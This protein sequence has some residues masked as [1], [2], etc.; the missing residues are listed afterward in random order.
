MNKQRHHPPRWANRLLQWY[1]ASHLLEEIEG[2][3][4]EEFDY[5]IAKSGLF[6][7]KIDYIRNV[8]GFLKP[9]AMRRKK[10]YT[11][12][13]SSM[14]MI[15]HYLLMAFRNLVR[16]KAFGAIN[17][18][19]LAL[20]MTCCIFIYLWIE[21]E[22]SMDNFHVNG[23]HLF[24]VYQT[25][26]AEGRVEGSYNTPIQYDS[27]GRIIPI[28]DIGQVAPEVKSISFFATGYEL[29]W[30]HPETL[31]VGDRIHKWNGARANE[32]FL[33]MFS[34]PVIAGDAATALRGLNSMAISKKLAAVYFGSPENAIGKSIRYENSADFV[35]NAVFENLPNQS[36]QQFE[37]LLN[38]ES[39]MTRLP[40]ASPVALTTLQ[41]VDGADVRNVE[42]KL[43]RLM[44][45]RMDPQA[46]F[47]IQLGLQPFRDQYLI[48][49]FVNGKPAGGR[50]QYVNIFTAV[51]LFIL[52]IACINFM[53]LATARSIRRAKEVGV[54]KAVGSS[55]VGLIGQFFGE[56]MVFSFIALLLSIVL[57]YCLLPAFNLF[58]GKSIA[59]PFHSVRTVLGLLSL[60]V[61]TGF[62]S[63]SYPALFLSSLKPAGI[64]KGAL[65]F[66]KT[67]IFFRK[68]LASFQFA[69]SI[70]LLI[71]TIVMTRQTQFISNANIG[72]DRENLIYISI[73]GVLSGQQGYERFKHELTKIPGVLMVDRATET[74]HAMTF[75]V[76]LA[77]DGKTETA[78][79]SDAIN[80]EGKVNGSHAGFKPMS[81]GFDFIPTLNLKVAEGRGF[82]RQFSTDSAD[83][84]M[85]NEE[86]VKQ[87]G[88]KDPIGKWVSAWNKKGHIV[89]VLK[90]YN[91]HS[92]H[93]TIKP[94]I[95][96]VKE[97]ENFGVVMVRLEAGKTKET[98]TE[99]GK[100]YKDINPS[101]AFSYQFLDEEYDKLY[102]SEQVV[103]K[104]SSAFA[105]LAIIISCL[106]L[107]GLVMFSAEQRT[108]EFGIRKVLGASVRNI[109][110]LLSQD[111][112]KLV[113]ISFCVAAPLA[114][115]IMHQWLQNF[116]YKIELS[117][118]IFALAGVVALLIALLT[119]AY[120][121]IQSA[122]TNPVKSLKVE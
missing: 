40:W 71:G 83:A 122:T 80:W 48:A 33:T 94:L 118:W 10:T 76:D 14:N 105:V 18:V 119:I 42:A 115:Y 1:C 79:D 6:K 32:N 46:P 84:F 106:G 49:Q 65:R 23:D 70:A 104:L 110:G 53:N 27:L 8:I 56:S 88:M 11:L 37:F 103:S 28:A 51:A 54:R 5:Q 66:S 93:E 112:L 36:T 113:I 26:T 78:D 31:Q 44:Q 91:T 96:D 52:V 69:I 121:A 15:K 45:S 73:E 98:L 20:G 95:V 81:V 82:S 90:N 120:Q 62:V 63:G 59:L 97:Y 64:L 30:G 99:I 72:Y 43:N 22:K 24:N 41:L 29:P 74:P 50:I 86:A 2:D 19:G 114:G 13:T 100:V 12:R 109:V 108:K 58:T 17:I 55:R 47:K 107:L 16:H 67:S 38:W 21:D 25:I 87:M 35:V 7:A 75:I 117:W 9:F 61:V 85:V 116:A 60:I 57:V 77:E 39:Q 34:Y 89:G 101:Y 92:L 4:Q 3:L 68:G 111:F 102:R